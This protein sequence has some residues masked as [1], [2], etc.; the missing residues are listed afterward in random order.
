MRTAALLLSLLLGAW[1]YGLQAQVAPYDLSLISSGTNGLTSA[2]AS[3]RISLQARQERLGDVIDRI[4]SLSGL[5]L[6]YSSDIVPVNDAISV[7]L[8]NVPVISALEHVLD[9]TG[10]EPRPAASG[11]VVLVRTPRAVEQ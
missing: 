11:Y 6:S 7:S 5:N 2:A 1:T 8:R 10:V 4:S 3:A 9:G